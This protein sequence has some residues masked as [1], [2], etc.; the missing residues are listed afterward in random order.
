M[1]SIWNYPSRDAAIEALGLDGFLAAVT[2]RCAEAPGQTAGGRQLTGPAT[3]PQGVNGAQR[4]HAIQSPERE[5]T[6]Q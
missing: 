2:Q 4:L 6:E 3:S 5:R 1:T